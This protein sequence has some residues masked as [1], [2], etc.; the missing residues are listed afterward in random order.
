MLALRIMVSAAMLAFLSTRVH[1][2]SLLP[3]RQASTI[4]W[5]MAGMA[6]WLVAVLISVVRWK[7]VLAAL[8]L[9]TPLS[10]LVSHS[11]AGLFVA[12][13]LPSTVGGDFLRVV[14][15][16]ADNGEAPSS[17]ASVVLERLTGFLVLP[18]IT[19]VALVTHPSLLHLGTASRLAMAL[20]LGSLATLFAVVAVAA[21]SRLGGR[22][23]GHESWLRFFGA[24]HLGVDRMRR[25]P[26]ASALVLGVALMYQLTVVA[27]AF[28]AS[29]ALGITVGWVPMMAFV[30]VVA[31]AQ[32]LPVSVG[33]L[34]LREGALVLLLHPLGVAA[35]QATALGLLLYGINLVV[36]LLGAPSFAVRSHASRAVA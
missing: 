34:G 21:N 26:A 3:D 15:L 9:P 32:V 18:L 13:F 7:Q 29:R 14:R 33:G 19:L 2:A 6:V 10:P 20:S 8:E 35:A 1:L 16:S 5:V 11:L 28:A 12:N 22:L 36:S 23:A 17:F 27:A 4:P 31:I 25:H 24:V 30:P